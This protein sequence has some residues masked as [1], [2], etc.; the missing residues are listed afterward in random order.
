MVLSDE[1]SRALYIKGQRT[2]PSDTV[3]YPAKLAH[4]NII[5]L[6]EKGVDYIF[7]PCMPYNFD[8]GDS[9]NNYNCPVVAY[10]PSFWRQYPGLKKAKFLMPY[11]GLHRPADFKKHAGQ[12]FQK[13][14]NVDYDQIG[15]ATDMAYK[16]YQK[17]RRNIDRTGARIIEEARSRAAAFWCSAA[18]PTTSIPRSATASTSS[19]L[20]TASSSSLRT[21]CSTA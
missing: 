10:Y 6:M 14:M 9:D 11:F 8:E 2:I 13:E 21:P 17:W 15:I 7:Y 3:C 4:G 5:S 16:A 19:A 12:I 18:G 20:N 1:S